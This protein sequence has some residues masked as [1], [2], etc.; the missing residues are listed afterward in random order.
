MVVLER[1][2]IVRSLVTSRNRKRVLGCISRFNEEGTY[3]Q[4]IVK[5]TGISHSNVLGAIFGSS[6]DYS[7]DLSLKSLGLVDVIEDGRY[8]Y[9]KITDKGLKSCKFIKGCV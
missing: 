1:P 3:L 7:M 4:E 8:R 5:E 6:R 9:Y 2:R